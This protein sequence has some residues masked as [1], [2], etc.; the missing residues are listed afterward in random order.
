MQRV[1]V[2]SL[3]ILSVALLGGST[4]RFSASSGGKKKK[5]DSGVQVVVDT[6][7]SGAAGEFG[8]AASVATAVAVSVLPTS[9]LEP[10]AAAR[11]SGG[12]G[13]GLVLGPEDLDDFAS[14]SISLASGATPAG[15]SVPEA[16]AAWLFASGVTL[17]GWQLRRRP[18]RRK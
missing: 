5:V 1:L 18:L 10:T 15:G 16:D 2:L 3:L 9:M 14:R 8:S 13:G 12:S 17:A 4:C 6:R 11:L 7:T